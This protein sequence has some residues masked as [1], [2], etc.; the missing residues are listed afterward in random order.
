MGPPMHIIVLRI[1]TGAKATGLI[2]RAPAIILLHPDKSFK[3]HTLDVQWKTH[4]DKIVDFT[5]LVPSNM[6]IGGHSLGGRWHSTRSKG[7]V[8]FF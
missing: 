4:I 6:F 1:L 2:K 3:D 7:F 8:T 5:I